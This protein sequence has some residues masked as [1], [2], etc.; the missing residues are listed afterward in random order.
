MGKTSIRKIETATRGFARKGPWQPTGSIKHVF[1]T[2]SVGLLEAS[3]Q[4]LGCA[5]PHERKCRQMIE[6]ILDQERCYLVRSAKFGLMDAGNTSRPGLVDDRNMQEP[7]TKTCSHRLSD[8]RHAIMCRLYEDANLLRGILWGPC[9][10]HSSPWLL[11]GSR[12]C[13][14]WT[15]SWALL[16][17]YACPQVS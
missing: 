10:L 4:G 15:L 16:D 3:K 5:S 11:F 1:W 6:R 8:P 13:S 12:S 2:G 9:D 17:P 7:S 14:A